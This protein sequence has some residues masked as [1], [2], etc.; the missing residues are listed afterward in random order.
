[1]AFLHHQTV[2]ILLMSHKRAPIRYI[3]MQELYYFLLGTQKEQ[4]LFNHL[5]QT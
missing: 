1:M 2:T 5:L 4:S 3:I